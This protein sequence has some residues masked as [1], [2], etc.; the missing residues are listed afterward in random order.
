[1]D[2]A[3]EVLRE[4]QK[5]S[6]VKLALGSEQLTAQEYEQRKAD[7]YNASTGNLNEQD[8]HDCPICKNKGYIAGVQYFDLY[9][10]YG[11][12]HRP[13]KCMKARN[14]LRRLARSGL[15]DVVKKYT[16][17]NYETPDAWQQSIKEK[18]IE[19]AADTKNHWFFMGG[20][21]GCGK[22]H[23]CTAIAIHMLRTGRD[24]RYMVWPKEIQTIQAS[25]GDAERYAA[26]MKELEETE[27]LYIDD[28]FKHGNDEFGRQ[29]MPSEPEARR[30]F[31][32]I[33]HRLNIPELTTIISSELTLAQL[34]DID[35][36]TAG[37][38]AER[39]KDVGY[40]INVRKDRARNWRMRGL[41]EV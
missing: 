16:F 24:V 38:I 21:S 22:T 5:K 35:E 13:C 7:F 37:R 6:P 26:L 8:G 20:Q 36:A 19:F 18:A 27:V 23:L 17:D 34:I 40:C 4:I 33:N 29:K 14:A 9:G 2:Q 1:M 12:V 41:D 15:K 10:Y 30:A 39:T 32:I 25:V 11:E 3:A 28:L 31:E